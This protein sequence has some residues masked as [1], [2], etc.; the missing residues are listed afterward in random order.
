MDARVWK[1]ISFSWDRLTNL[2]FP[3]FR[4]EPKWKYKL[5]TFTKK[6][7]YKLVTT[8]KNFINK[9]YLSPNYDSKRDLIKKIT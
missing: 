1:C 5:V 7:K 3:F 2:F 9:N 8:K 6:K 4:V